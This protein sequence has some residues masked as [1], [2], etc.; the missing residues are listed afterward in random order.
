MRIVVEQNRYGATGKARLRRVGATG[1]DDRNPRPEHDAGKLRT[2][3]IFKLLGQH[4][5]AFE[6]RNH[7]DVG[8]TRNRGVRGV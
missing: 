1:E 8:L 4:V 5:A 7:Q 2:A 6:V 3:Q